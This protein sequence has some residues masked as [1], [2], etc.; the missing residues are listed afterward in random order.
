[1]FNSYEAQR[2]EQLEMEIM[3]AGKTNPIYDPPPLRIGR[4]VGHQRPLSSFESCWIAK[5]HV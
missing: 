2:Y 5:E 1:V 4:M 3:K